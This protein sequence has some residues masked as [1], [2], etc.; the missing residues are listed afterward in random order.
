MD[1]LP[2]P[3][4]FCIC[5]ASKQVFTITARSLQSC[6]GAICYTE[7]LCKSFLQQ[8]NFNK[9]LRYNK[10][11]TGIFS[12]L[13]FIYFLST[14]TH[15]TL[16]YKKDSSLWNELLVISVSLCT[17]DVVYRVHHYT[18]HTRAQQRAGH[19]QGYYERACPLICKNWAASWKF[20][21]ATFVIEQCEFVG[22]KIIH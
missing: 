18:S 19:L 17:L 11:Y 15:T 1:V 13:L 3:T 6:L 2:Q 22:E 14:N 10:K 12:I 20:M 4:R 5:K 9:I 21:Q 16:T 8:A 7:T